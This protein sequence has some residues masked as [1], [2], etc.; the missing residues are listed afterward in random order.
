[1]P[2]Y[3]VV[4][5]I[6]DLCKMNNRQSSKQLVDYLDREIHKK[7]EYLISVTP[8]RK[9]VIPYEGEGIKAK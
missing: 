9:R 3:V 2:K 6:R 1:M 4:K 8:R 7:L 5:S